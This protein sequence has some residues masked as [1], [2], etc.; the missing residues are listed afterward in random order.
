MHGLGRSSGREHTSVLA[1][2]DGFRHLLDREG[3]KLIRPLQVMVFE[4]WFVYLPY[5][6]VL[7]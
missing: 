4:R 2:I 5:Y 1:E 3:L 6:V 7:V